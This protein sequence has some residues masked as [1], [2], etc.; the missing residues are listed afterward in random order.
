MGETW[1]STTAKGN[2]EK[3]E[4]APAGATHQ[5]GTQAAPRGD[6]WLL[7]SQLSPS[8]ALP[9]NQLVLGGG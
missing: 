9:A 5:R 1:H 6:V 3:R 2:R 8:W 4:K 7:T